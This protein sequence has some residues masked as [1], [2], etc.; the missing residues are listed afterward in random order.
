MVLKNTVY[1][2]ECVSRAD[3]K[4]IVGVG[5]TKIDWDQIRN[6]EVRLLHYWKVFLH[7]GE[8]GGMRRIQPQSIICDNPDH[9]SVRFKKADTLVDY[10]FTIERSGELGVLNCDQREFFFETHDDPA[11]DSLLKAIDLFGEFRQRDAGTSVLKSIS[12]I[13]GSQNSYGVVIRT[14]NEDVKFVFSIEDQGLPTRV[15][16][17]HASEIS[18]ADC[19]K[20]IIVLF[21]RARQHE[22]EASTQSNP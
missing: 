7:G 17:N 3:N 13:S 10:A 22:C 16:A 4:H 11:T 19:I 1:T 14:D 15:S 9:Y 6:D 20:Q 5:A 12:A 8:V 2:T 21:H 18:D